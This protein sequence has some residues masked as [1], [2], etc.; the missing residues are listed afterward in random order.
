MSAA[1]SLLSLYTREGETAALVTAKAGALMLVN[2][3]TDSVLNCIST[4]PICVLV[5]VVIVAARTH[6]GE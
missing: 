4:S 1:W 5:M 6:Q 3:L 2:S